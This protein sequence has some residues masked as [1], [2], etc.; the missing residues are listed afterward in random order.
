M[1]G[2]PGANSRLVVPAMSLGQLVGVVVADSTRPAAFGAQDE[3]V[4]GVVGTMLGTA[5]EH[6]RALERQT[7]EA[8][9]ARGGRAGSLPDPV[10]VTTDV[11]F[12]EVDGSTFLDGEYLIK[13]VAGR[14]LWSLLRQHA[15]TGRVEFTNRELRLD[16]SLQLPGFKD[17]L[18]SRLILLKRRLDERGAT[19]RLERTGAGGSGSMSPS[20]CA[21]R[22]R[23]SSAR[24]DSE[25]A[26]PAGQD[27]Q[28]TGGAVDDGGR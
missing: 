17:N 15:A 26:A 7:D 19:I 18:E 11:R 21:C 8:P 22:A 24:I 12:F 20:P 6:V 14:I 16:P 13:G 1:P 23:V 27:V 3:H 28:L 2:L 4:L 25:D 5:I 10:G 9:A